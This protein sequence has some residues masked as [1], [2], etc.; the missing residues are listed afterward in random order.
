MN[1]AVRNSQSDSSG[2]EGF[3]GS[4]DYTSMMRQGRI[5]KGTPLIVLKERQ[6]VHSK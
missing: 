3:Y 6:T 5:A 4:K 1:Y 2:M